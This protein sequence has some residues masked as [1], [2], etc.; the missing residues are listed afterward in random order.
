[1]KQIAGYVGCTYTQG[2]DNCLTVENL[3]LPV[4]QGPTAPTTTDALTVAIFREEVKEFVKRT[5]KLEENVQL[6]WTLIWGQ[7]LGAVH[8]KLEARQDHEDM[9]QW[10]AGVE[11]LNAIKGLMYNIQELKYLPL[12]IHL[13]W[14]HF[15]SSSQ[16]H[17][18]DAAHYLEQF[19]NPLDILERCGAALGEDPGTMC[20]AFEQEGID[21]LTTDEEELQQ[22]RTIAREWYLALAFLMGADHTCFG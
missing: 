21:P 10:S 13:A 5:K 6:L 16:Q 3:T 9:C 17:H 4:L 1:M 14:C 7:A 18:M 22:V 19:N 2:G 11:L 20:K 15:C 12:A 8:T